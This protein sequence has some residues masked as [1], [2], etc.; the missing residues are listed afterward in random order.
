MKKFL[1]IACIYLVSCS[2]TPSEKMAAKQ[3]SLSVWEPEC[4]E[5]IDFNKTNGIEDGIKYQMYFEATLRIKKPC[6]SFKTYPDE[7]TAVTQ[8][9]TIHASQKQCKGYF[10]AG[11]YI[12]HDIICHQPNDRYKVTGIMYFVK[13]EKG[14]LPSQRKHEI[15]SFEKLN[16]E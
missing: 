15:E 6:E 8:F 13:T 16:N 10:Y 9:R 7:S 12:L 2:N 5:L 4:I 1:I 11:G 3:L 14:W